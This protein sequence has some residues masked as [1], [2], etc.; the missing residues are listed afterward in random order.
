ML[1]AKNS[2]AAELEYDANPR[3]ADMQV[4]GEQTEHVSTHAFLILQS[5]FPL[6]FSLS[7][8]CLAYIS[9]RDPITL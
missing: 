2:L 9:L 1:D 4:F 5:L 8:P 6:A 3:V 7:Q